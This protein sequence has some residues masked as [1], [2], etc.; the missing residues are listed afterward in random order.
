MGAVATEAEVVLV[1]QVGLTD[2]TG[3]FADVQVRRTGVGDVN[4]VVAALGLD[5]AEHGLELADD[6]DIAPDADKILVLEIYA[7]FSDR[8][9]IYVQG[10]FGK[11]KFAAGMIFC[12]IHKKA[13]RHKMTSYFCQ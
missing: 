13:F 10:D 6:G 12:R 4:A 3:L 7:L 5:A 11:N 9:I 8:T 1:E 2:R